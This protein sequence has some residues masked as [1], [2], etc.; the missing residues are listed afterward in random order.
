MSCAKAAGFFGEVDAA[1]ACARDNQRVLF[2]TF[3]TACLPNFT[4]AAESLPSGR[5]HRHSKFAAS[6]LHVIAS[7]GENPNTF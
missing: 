3:K 6:T 5:I 7:G 2:E 4:A 1:I